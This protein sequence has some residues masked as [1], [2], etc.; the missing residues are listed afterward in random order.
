MNTLNI[1]NQDR[2]LI[3]APHPDDECIGPGGILC[4]YPQLCD[5]FVLTDGAQGQGNSTLEKCRR[6]RRDEFQ[7]EMECLGIKNY[8]LFDIPDGMLMR[9][10]DCLDHFDLRSY[11]KFFVTGCKDNHA[12]HTAAY[13]CLVH[14]LESQNINNAEI[15]LYE[16]H[17]PL[18]Q[19]T[20]YLD[21]TGCIDKKVELIQKHASQLVTL[22]Y[23]RYA[24]I[25]AEYRAL[26]NRMNGRMI[27]VY[28]KTG[29]DAEA[30]HQKISLENDLQKFKRFYGV[31]TK[32]MLSTAQRDVGDVLSDMG[33]RSCV[34]YG[35]AE[36]GKILRSRLKG[37]GVKLAYILDKKINEDHDNVRFFY[38][39]KE[40]PDTD[41]V[42]VTAI[43]YYDEIKRELE[44]YGY[45]NIISLEELV[46]KI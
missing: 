28:S 18:E 20:H 22:P 44:G 15:Y 26:Q 34:I 45:G 32:W 31:L 12:D 41:I 36:L 29:T 25:S 21:I 6:I 1:S 38:P 33:I 3:L 14:A 8:R 17:N 16:V 9:H 10:P 2:I 40:V 37:S 43:Y 23:D 35:Y 4:L 27:E 42:I 39:G 30:D 24:R 19:P 7:K 46:D 11:T 13:L 5:V